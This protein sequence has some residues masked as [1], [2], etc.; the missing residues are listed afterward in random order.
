MVQTLTSR[1]N[2]KYSIADK[3]YSSEVEPP[4]YYGIIRL[5]KQFNQSRQS[6]G[7]LTTLTERN[8]PTGSLQ[9][10][11]N[12]SAGVFGVDGWSFLD[13]KKI[14]VIN[15][16]MGMSHLTGTPQQ[17]INLESSSTHYFQRPDFHGYHIDSSATSLTGFGGRIRLNKERGPVLV[18]AAFG[19]MGPRFDL[20]DVGFM[21][22]NNIINAHFGAAYYWSEPTSW[23]R[24]FLQ[25]AAVYT[26]FDYNGNNTTLGFFYKGRFHFLNYYEV[27]WSF[28]TS[29]K[30]IDDR[31][32]RGGPL[33]LSLP[34]SEWDLEFSSDSRKKIILDG[35]VYGTSQP[36]ESHEWNIYAD[37]EYKPVANITFKVGP[38]YNMN[39]NN[40][41]WVNAFDDPTA[42]AT[43]GKRYVFA[44]L[45]QK[46][47]SASI[48]LNWTFTP[49]LSLQMYMQPLISSGK[50]TQYKA[51]QRPRSYDFLVFGRDGKSTFD[52][53]TYIADPDGNGPAPSMT[54]DNPDFN[55]KSLRGNAVLRWEYRRGS[56]LY[57]VWTQSRNETTDYGYFDFGHSLNRF[58]TTKPNNIFLV[59]FSYWLKSLTES[60]ET[61][62]LLR[63]LFYKRTQRRHREH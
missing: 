33:A 31:L 28:S 46:T 14:W 7:I 38:Q 5:Q 56:T 58:L 34:W 62:C 60:S 45:D 6:I 44:S 47:V 54:I 41:Q 10:Q 57:L 37:I 39:R 8:L 23:Y 49:A 40:S 20:N 24:D 43:Y 15:G 36:G 1:E 29:P 35:G 59:K 9:N 4:S 13:K 55:Y 51:L 17:M 2:A 50:Y 22:M 48:R 21:G 11:L 3:I 61:Q 19:F 63:F 52:Q 18:N 42:I 26:N 53:Q 16:W 25:L 32:T 27:N 30:T 12:K